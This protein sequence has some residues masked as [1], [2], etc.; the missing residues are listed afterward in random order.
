MIHVA[1]CGRLVRPSGARSANWSFRWPAIS[2]HRRIFPV[3]KFLISSDPTAAPSPHPCAVARSISISGVMDASRASRLRCWEIFPSALILILM[4]SRRC[5]V[6]RAMVPITTC[7][8]KKSLPSLRLSRMIWSRSHLS[9]GFGVFVFGP[10]LPLPS[11][12]AHD[13]AC[14]GLVRYCVGPLARFS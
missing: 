14:S 4:R 8:E 10:H 5:L 2:V 1:E 13:E 9:C 11:R 6:N 7:S 12:P 3:R